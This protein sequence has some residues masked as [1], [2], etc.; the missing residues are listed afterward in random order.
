METYLAYFDILGFK[1]YINNT[2][3]DD[4]I[5]RFECLFRDS[6]SAI[7]QQS[8]INDSYGGLVPN[9][10]L[11]KANCLHIS[12]SIIFWTNGSETEDFIALVDICNN[13]FQSCCVNLT[14]PLRGCIVKGQIEFLP[15]TV[16]NKN[17]NTFI[18][19]SLYGKALIDAYLKAENQDW[20]G[21]YVDRSA[22]QNIDDEIINKLITN[23]SILRYNVPIKNGESSMEY[24]IKL[25]GKNYNNINEDDLITLFTTQLN[26]QFITEKIQQKIDNTLKY[27]RHIK[28]V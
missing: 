4:V 11:F 19:S 3:S 26:C 8:Y 18:N 17:R 25:I 1:S 24:T 9:K 28:K 27:L 13:F 21:C 2:S 23:G 20:A 7:A 22:Y 12:D 10:D 14:F 15:F 6:Q 16:Q 5:F